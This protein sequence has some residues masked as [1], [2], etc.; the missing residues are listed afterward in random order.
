MIDPEVHRTEGLVSEI[1]YNEIQHNCF[2][3]DE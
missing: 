1:L 3:W 2:L